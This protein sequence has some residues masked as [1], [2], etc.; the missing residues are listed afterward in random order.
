MA[1]LA[2]TAF[3]AACSSNVAAP[4][5][6]PAPTAIATSPTTPSASST[7]GLTS[8]PLAGQVTAF[9]VLT[10]LVGWVALRDD[11]GATLAKTS[12]AGRTW[13]RVGPARIASVSSLDELRFIDERNA[14]AVAFD[15]EATPRKGIVLATEDGGATWTER[16]VA[17]APSGLPGPNPLRGLVVV[18]DR[19]AWVV[20][21][22]GPCD[23]EGCVSELRATAD[24]GVSWS[25]SY[26]PTGAMIGVA[27]FADAS[28]GWLT[29]S[30]L[31]RRGQQLLGTS[32]GGRS[33]QVSVAADKLQP[34][35]VFIGLSAPAPPYLWA[36]SFDSASC[37]GDGCE[38]YALRVSRDGGL[39]WMTVHALDADA[40]WWRK[41][42][43]G[44]F[45]GAPVFVDASHGLIPFGQGAGGRSP[46]NPGGLLVTDDGGNTF[47][48][49][50]VT[51]VKASVEIRFANARVGWAIAFTIDSKRSGYRTVDGGATWQQMALPG[52]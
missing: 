41:E 26:R 35:E 45:L 18:D 51:S 38:R 2:L 47:R 32:D 20:V 16:L 9:D 39:T 19:H 44:G 1:L 46:E 12:D 3:A 15:E 17:G 29:E 21:T 37:T 31:V 11:A 30:A 36:F 4:T 13:Q 6:S 49:V 8:P 52:A 33:W 40:S 22:T 50:R 14:F 43:C 34:T 28:R 25:T 48:C 7:P 27:T 24:A 5:P 23:P 42:G 10:E